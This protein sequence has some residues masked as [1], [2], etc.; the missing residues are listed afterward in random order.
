MEEVLKIPEVTPHNKRK[1]ELNY[2][3]CIICQE[4]QQK[5][6]VT[7]VIAVESIEILL[8]RCRERARYKDSKVIDFTERVKNIT[9]IDILN[10][11]GF[12]HRECYK[13]F[14][15]KSEMNRA[16]KRY[17]DALQQSCATS[18]KRK[19]GRPSTAKYK[20]ETAEESML[21][22]SQTVPYDKTLCIICQRAEGILHMVQVTSTGHSIHKVAEQLSDKSFFRRLNSISAAN[23]VTANDVQYHNLCWAKAKRE[24]ERLHAPVKEEDYLRTL[25]D[26]E[27]IHVIDVHLSDPSRKILDLNM[28]NEI[29]LNILVNNGREGIH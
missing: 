23:D 19:I 9:A 10:N 7:K 4:N 25:S 16:E 13:I 5:K 11:K 15:N 22:R 29:Y 24:A 27:L 20:E 18:I 17:N 28:I 12:Y 8:Y 21:R 26:I 2:N 14:S 1:S 6:D 3:L